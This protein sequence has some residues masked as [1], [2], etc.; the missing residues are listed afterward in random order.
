MATLRIPIA[1]DALDEQTEITLYFT[2]RKHEVPLVM[3]RMGAE[4]V[5]VSRHQN[6]AQPDK[7]INWNAIKAAGRTF[8]FLR[9]TLGTSGRDPFFIQNWQGA[10]AAGLLAG[11]Y[12]YL[13]HNLNG[14]VQADNFLNALGDNV[15]ELPPVLDLEPREA[16]KGNIN[17]AVC[18]ENMRQ[19]LARVEAVT[20]RLPMIYTNA[21]ALGQMVNQAGR[22][23]LAQYPLWMAA[24]TNSAAVPN[25]TPTWGAVTCWQYSG[26]GTLPGVKGTIDLNRWIA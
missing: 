10:R 24:Y 2:R 6:D 5:D 17:P 9:A 18:L 3:P 12:H 14:Q 8:A 7:Q 4:G 15:G 23:A 11:G 21:A 13:I 1:L 16:D 26:S 22:G 19:W 20:G 25:P